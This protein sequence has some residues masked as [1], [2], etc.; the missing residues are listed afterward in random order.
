MAVG[1]GAI[2]AWLCGGAAML[3][4]GGGAARAQSAAAASQAEADSAGGAGD[5]VVSASRSGDAISRD[6]IG[7]SV[8]VLGA[9]ALEER[10]T[11][12]V[13]DVLRDVPGVAVSRSGAVGG[14]TQVR[15]R[16]SEGNHVLVIIDGIKA[17]D[18]Y[19]GEFDF[20]TLMADDAARIE[21]LRGQQ[22]SLYGSSAI[23]G[24]IN[25]ITLSGREAPG[26]RTS[27]EYGAMDTYRA[28]ARLAGAAGD[29]DYA[30][31]GAA[32]H[33]DGYAVAPG[34]SREVGARL[35][36]GS[37]KVNWTPAPDFKLTAVGRY[38]YTRGENT[39]TGL[40]PD[41]PT[42]DGRAVQA[43]IDTPGSYYVNR[44]TYGLVRAELD[45][46][47]GAMSTAASA[48]VADT[49]RRN[50]RSGDFDYGDRG[51]R[52]RYSLEDTLR[53]GTD[54][55]K[56]R[57]TFALDYEREQFRNTTPADFVDRSRHRLDTLGFVGQYNLTV[58]ERLAIGGS[59][60]HDRNDLFKDVTTYHV[61]ASYLLPGGTR[62][63]AA[64]GTG[65]E[66]P[67]AF[68]LFGYSDGLY[69]GNPDLRPEKSKGWEAGIDQVFGGGKVRIGAT[70][71]QNRLH[72]EI[73]TDYPAPDFVATSFNRT[74]TTRQRGVETFLEA[75]AGAVRADA[76]YTYLRAPQVRDVLATPA[77]T[78]A[79]PLESQAVRRAKNIASLNVSYAPGE[80][81][82]TVTATIR[83]NGA[84]NDVAYTGGF[85]PVLAR[86][87]DFTLLNLAA[88]YD[89]NRQLQ[90]FGRIENALRERYQEVFGYRA[91]GRAVYAGARLKL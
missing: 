48:Q 57:L 2:W 69:I 63:R 50:Y 26:L 32:Q 70:Y 18:P 72:A 22:S 43:A 8:T 79:T 42:V 27:A 90:L 76:S 89:L 77:A 49:R 86:V 78:F 35:A 36:G 47:G 75:R 68:E 4:A 74:S 28:T 10:Q 64:A 71:F 60:R 23:G 58:D 19:Q 40:N 45:T 3:A 56:H 21:V 38:S 1:R 91:A 14:L 5:I 37:G 46:F 34:G 80:R 31:S 9:Q 62:I 88:T 81:P 29:L 20:G 39:D 44:G 59:I 83:Y 25:Y 17:D 85:D 13:S 16:G 65:S 87:D 84:Q 41:A 11:R 7:S 15:I 33:T 51:Q 55:V 61:D 54:R 66:N 53:L 30:L 52:Q 6:L 12:M 24:V 82:F 73:Y 67:A